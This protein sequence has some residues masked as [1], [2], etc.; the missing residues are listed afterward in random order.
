MFLDVIF[1]ES[2]RWLCELCREELPLRVSP[3]VFLGG[4]DVDRARRDERDQLVLV[5]GQ[6]GLD[7]PEHSTI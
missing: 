5:D 2:A 7:I 4:R 1:P 3:E 6:C